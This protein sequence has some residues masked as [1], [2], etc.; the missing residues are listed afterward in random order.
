LAESQDQTIPE[1]KVLKKSMVE[2]AAP[3]PSVPDLDHPKMQKVIENGFDLPI[4]D[5]HKLDIDEMAEKIRDLKPPAE[6]ED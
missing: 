3:L 1:P 5:S 6:V 2:P 4:P